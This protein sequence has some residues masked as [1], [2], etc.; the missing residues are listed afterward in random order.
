MHLIHH[1]L[2]RLCRLRAHLWAFVLRKGQHRLQEEPRGAALRHELQQALRLVRHEALVLGGTLQQLQEVGRLARAQRGDHRVVVG[3][4]HVLERHQRALLHGRA[5]VAN[6]GEG[7][8]DRLLQ[9]GLQRRLVVDREH[10]QRVE[11]LAR[12]H[13][14]LGREL[15]R[16]SLQRLAHRGL[17][18]GLQLVGGE[19]DDLHADGLHA[20]GK[21][22][23]ALLG[24]GGGSLRGVR[25]L[26]P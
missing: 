22:H 17:L 15:A 24:G 16:Q 12:H 5:Q 21:L 6:V 4:H 18:Q 10:P 9:L 25:L 1:H 2:Q 13:P 23:G 8:G 26:K 14:V 3:S 7:E 19:I 20:V 11:P